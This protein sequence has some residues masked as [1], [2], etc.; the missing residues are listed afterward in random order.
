MDFYVQRGFFKNS[1]QVISPNPIKTIDNVQIKE[2]KN[3]YYLFVGQLEKHKGIE[4]L[5]DVWKKN[6]VQ[7]ELLIIGKGSQEE[8]LKQQLSD[9]IKL[10][11]CKRGEEFRQLISQVDFLIVPSL[12]YE[13]SPSVIPLAF[14]NATPVI[15]ANIGGAAELVDEGKTGFAFEA[16]NEESLLNAL[17]KVDQISDV[18]YK[19]MSQ[20]CQVQA[21]NFSVEKYLERIISL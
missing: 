21:E 10:L 11:G 8:A 6:S 7:G 13:N 4:W 20:T 5:I 1:K 18:E 12:C 3:N 19:E 9:K 16:G 2:K 17:N 14:Q 15:V